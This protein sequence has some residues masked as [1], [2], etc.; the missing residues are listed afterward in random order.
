MQ[1]DAAVRPADLKVFWETVEKAGLHPS[2]PRAIHAGLT[3]VKALWEAEAHRQPVTLEMAERF[4]DAW[5]IGWRKWDDETWV[6]EIQA[7]LEKAGFGVVREDG[8]E[9]K[10]LWIGELLF[11][12]D[13]QKK[14]ITSLTSDLEIAR[15]E[16]EVFARRSGEAQ[17]EL[18]EVQTKLEEAAKQPLEA[19][20]AIV[21]SQKA[22]RYNARIQVSKLERELAEVQEKLE[23]SEAVSRVLGEWHGK[24]QIECDELKA[25]AEA[26]EAKLEKAER[27]GEGALNTID[28][29]RDHNRIVEAERDDALVKVTATLAAY[30]AIKKECNEWKARAEAAETENKGLHI[31]KEIFETSFAEVEMKLKSAEAKLAQRGEPTAEQVETPDNSSF[32]LTGSATLT[33]PNGTSMTLTSNRLSLHED[34]ILALTEAV[35]LTCPDDRFMAVCRIAAERLKEGK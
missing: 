12:Q 28:I 15:H 23:E 29:A 33:L 34:C 22:E 8:A 6:G 18:T 5:N 9:A 1:P 26:A 10:R 32:N 31:R 30:R 25:R 24:L 27:L 20:S 11:E 7:A 4:A 17:R 2:D 14:L 19:I 3:A 21:E 35:G 13:A 16:R